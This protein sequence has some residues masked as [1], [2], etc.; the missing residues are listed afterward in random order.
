MLPLSGPAKV[1][2]LNNAAFALEQRADFLKLPLETNLSRP[3][4]KFV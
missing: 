4:L 2:R 3:S 1:K